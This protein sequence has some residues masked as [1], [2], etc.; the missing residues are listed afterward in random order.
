MA[1]S[2]ISLSSSYC[3]I[4]FPLERQRDIVPWSSSSLSQHP[5]SFIIS[6]LSFDGCGLRSSCRGYQGGGENGNSAEPA[7]D[8]PG[9]GEVAAIGLEGGE[10]EGKEERTSCGDDK[11]CKPANNCGK[12]EGVT[13][14][15]G[16]AAETTPSSSSPNLDKED[17]EKDQTMKRLAKL[18]ADYEYIQ[19]EHLHELESL[20]KR[21]ETQY[22]PLIEKR[23]EIIRGRSDEL[24]LRGFWLV[25]MLNHGFLRQFITHQDQKCLEYL[26]DIRTKPLPQSQSGFILEFEFD[27]ANPYFSDHII[28]KTYVSIK[29][30]SQQMETIDKITVSPELNDILPKGVPKKFQSLS[31]G[32]KE[33]SLK[34][35]NAPE[36]G[37]NEDFP[38]MQDEEQE[39]RQQEEDK[40][41]AALTPEERQER[42]EEDLDIASIFKNFLIPYAYRWFTGDAASQSGMSLNDAK[43]GDHSAA[44]DDY[45]APVD[46]ADDFEEVVEDEEYN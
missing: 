3:G 11:C 27:P 34:A 43:T 22:T 29:E 14:P 5:S 23:S 18:Q 46:A 21:Y 45:E 32:E 4:G 13:T 6:R 25:A 26:I 35:E 40:V 24:A 1:V 44:D 7:K 33:N 36:G 9:S 15:E 42:L 31:F 30:T 28:Q 16:F 8:T 41:N 12:Q 20:E 39:K 38:T 2:V 10:D 37:E 19:R 17:K